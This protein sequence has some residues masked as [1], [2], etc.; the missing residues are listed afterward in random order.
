MLAWL[1]LV[2]VGIA[3]N[4]LVKFFCPPSAVVDVPTAS[5]PDTSGLPKPD[6]WGT[7]RS[8]LYFGMRTKTPQA[9]MTGLIWNSVDDIPGVSSKQ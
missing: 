5:S 1:S 3:F 8:N 9:L 2:P 6:I 7:Y 4:Y